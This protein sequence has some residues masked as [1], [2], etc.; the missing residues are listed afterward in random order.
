[1]EIGSAT[2][3]VKELQEQGVMGKQW[4]SA[5]DKQFSSCP[6]DKRGLYFNGKTS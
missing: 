6:F 2:L 1:M 3:L 4:V 5:T